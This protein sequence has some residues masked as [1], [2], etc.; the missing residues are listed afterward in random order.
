MAHEF[1]IQPIVRRPLNILDPQIFYQH[2]LVSLVPSHHNTRCVARVSGLQH[3]E[4][5]PAIKGSTKLDKALLQCSR[6]SR[7]VRPKRT[8]I[9]KWLEFIRNVAHLFILE[10][11]SRGVVHGWPIKRLNYLASMAFSQNARQK[12]TS[13][14]CTLITHFYV[15]YFSTWSIL[16]VKV[17]GD[18]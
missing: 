12:L 16:N 3:D 1:R 10:C 8:P 15:A 13:N 11:K 5:K 7:N 2:D 18:D 17:V 14:K 4:P 9:V 6:G